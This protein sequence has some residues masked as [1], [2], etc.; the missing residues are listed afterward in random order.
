MP[1]THQNS[2]INA[3]NKTHRCAPKFASG[4]CSFLVTSLI[5]SSSL[6]L[7]SLPQPHLRPSLS[8]LRECRLPDRL[9]SAVLLLP[10]QPPF[11]IRALPHRLLSLSAYF[12]HRESGNSFSHFSFSFF[13]FLYFLS[14]FRFLL[15]CISLLTSSFPLHLSY[16]FPTLTPP[17]LPSL[18][19]PLLLSSEM[20]THFIYLLKVV[21]PFFDHHL[22][23]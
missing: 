19:L 12:F 11:L 23:P 21:A 15:F 1:G 16:L 9:C 17:V 7:P 18:P 5:S 3:L 4:F 22:P 20:S 14:L 6:A 10:L 13:L 8:G 2:P